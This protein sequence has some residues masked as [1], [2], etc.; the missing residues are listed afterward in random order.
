MAEWLEH[1]LFLQRTWVI[2][3]Q[4]GDARPF[5]TPGLG[6][7]MTSSGFYRHCT[8]VVSRHACREKTHTYKIKNR[9]ASGKQARVNRETGQHISRF[10]LALHTHTRTHARTH[11]RA[12]ALWF[13]KV[14]P[15]GP[16]VKELVLLRAT[17]K[18]MPW[19]LW[20][21]SHWDVLGGK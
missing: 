14:S 19:P 18:K 12:R 5:V 10:T 13:M 3:A 11:A 4:Q 15:K 21:G 17:R 9:G 1:W 7:S 20:G 8:H 6:D 16:F 2:S